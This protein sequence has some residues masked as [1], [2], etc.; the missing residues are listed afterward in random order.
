MEIK[1]LSDVGLKRETNQDFAD[2][3]YNQMNRP[4]ILLADGM[5]GHRAGD[6]AS[7][8]AV[9]TLGIMWQNADFNEPE[10]VA[11]WLVQ[12]IQG[13]NEEIYAKG[14]HDLDYQ[15]MGTTIVA[16]AI[17][18]D[19]VTLAHVGDSRAYII[20]QNQIYQLT[21]DHSLVNELLQSGAINEEEA[22]NHPNKNVLTR[23]VGMP[24]T[25]EIDVTNQQFHV[26][27]YLLVASDGLTNMVNDEGILEILNWSETVEDKV[28]SLVQEANENGGRDNITVVLVSFDEG[29]V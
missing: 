13:L 18:D 25:V 1:F 4:L 14:E 8:L 16:A 22:E 19:S 2:V 7:R 21:S 3:Y 15:G 20:R 17:F 27:D 29:G 26:G 9:E 24:G 10:S 5:G 12:N 6:V 23:S 11:D 28:Y